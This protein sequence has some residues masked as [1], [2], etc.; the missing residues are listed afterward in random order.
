MEESLPFSL[1][2]LWIMCMLHFLCWVQHKTYLL[3]DQNWLREML[4]KKLFYIWWDFVTSLVKTIKSTF[5]NSKHKIST[6]SVREDNVASF[7]MPK[8]KKE[9]IALWYSLIIILYLFSCTLRYLPL[10][11]QF[12]FVK[13]FITF[14][15]H[16]LQLPV[17]KRIGGG[18]F[19]KVFQKR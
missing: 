12:W 13:C 19:I 16:V 3:I 5:F 2:I 14:R 4:L 10:L 6:A 15:W 17:N 9:T 7:K 11:D 18:G 1:R 8:K